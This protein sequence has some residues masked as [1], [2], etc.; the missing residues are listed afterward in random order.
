MI[1]KRDS[2]RAAVSGAVAVALFALAL[3]SCEQQEQSSARSV[4]EVYESDGVPV[5]VRPVAPTEFST[6]LRFTAGLSGAEESTATSMLSDEVA[7]VLYEVGD[8]VEKGSSVVVFPPDNPSLNYEQARVNFESARQAF[9]RLRR[10]YEQ[11]G[12]SEQAYDDARTRFEIARANWE[13]VQQMREV[14]A[15]ISGYLTRINVFES[16]NVTAGDALFTVSAYGEL[17]STVWLTDRQV[18]TVQTGQP[19]SA[20]WQEYTLSGR[21]VQVDMAM[22]EERKAFAARLRFDN[23]GRSVRSGV[24]ATVEIET[25][26]RDDALIVSNDELRSDEA[27]RFV[28]IVEEGNAAKRPVEIGRRQGLYFE[29]TGGLEPGMRIVTKGIDQLSP[30]DPVNIIEEEPRLVQR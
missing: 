18:R 7:G 9:E 25:S 4:E 20:T 24:T 21:V 30:G 23:P 5:N 12:V 14:A 8:Y 3:T 26:K 15:P 2:A 6:Y 28:Y 17:R 13:S 10:L 29:V 16:D 19:A 22:D 11:D 1:R 27:G